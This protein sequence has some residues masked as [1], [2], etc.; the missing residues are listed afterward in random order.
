L[1]AQGGPWRSPWAS[2]EG[3]GT[4]VRGLRPCIGVQGRRSSCKDF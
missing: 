4:P 1:L 3:L 2:G